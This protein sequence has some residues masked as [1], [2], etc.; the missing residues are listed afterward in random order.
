MV[1]RSP[2][3]D[4]E[5]S[6]EV[7]SAI[8]LYAACRIAVDKNYSDNLYVGHLRKYL[9]QYGT[10]GFLYAA[11]GRALEYP[12]KHVGR[13]IVDYVECQIA[14]DCGVGKADVGIVF[15]YVLRQVSVVSVKHLFG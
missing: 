2:C 4:R 11:F 15:L 14:R 12:L 3:P 5:L 8:L 13:E 1:L 10:V 7:V 9:L 6:A